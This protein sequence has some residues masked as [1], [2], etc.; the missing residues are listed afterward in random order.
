MKEQQMPTCVGPLLIAVICA[1][2]TVLC[3]WIARAVLSLPGAT[4]IAFAC[5]S[6]ALFWSA[7]LTVAALHWLEHR[8][9]TIEQK[10]AAARAALRARLLGRATPA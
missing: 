8:G 7:A 2:L 6:G 1:A 3:L 5:V 4:P 9:R 10:R